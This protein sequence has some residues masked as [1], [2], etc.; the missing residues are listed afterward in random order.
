MALGPRSAAKVTASTLQGGAV[1]RG[2]PAFL[3]SAW[4]RSIRPRARRLRSACTAARCCGTTR[5]SPRSC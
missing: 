4:F 2:D 1:G 5:A 3:G